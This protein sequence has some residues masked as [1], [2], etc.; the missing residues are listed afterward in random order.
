MN[1]RGNGAPQGTLYG[2]ETA[3]NRC[4]VRPWP[5]SHHDDELAA[6]EHHIVDHDRAKNIIQAFP[7]Q[8]E[9]DGYPC[10]RAELSF[11][12][13]INVPAPVCEQDVGVWR[14]KP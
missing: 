6:G 8:G 1:R 4:Q 7:F 5:S 2:I 11:L 9:S 13:F 3:V 12:S 10:L 14:I